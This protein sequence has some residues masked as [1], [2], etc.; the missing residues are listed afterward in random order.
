MELKEQNKDKYLS[1]KLVEVIN[2]TYTFP[3]G[4]LGLK[5]ISFTVEEGE[6]VVV[7]GPNGSGKTTLLL[8]LNGL[9]RGEGIIRLF[10]LDLNQKTL[11][12]IRK[13]LGLVFQNPDDQLFMPTVLDDVAFS[14]SYS[15]K[16]DLNKPKIRQ[17]KEDEGGKAQR[18]ISREAIVE[19]VRQI[20]KELNAENLMER[21]TFK[22]S[23][24]EKKKIALAGVLIHEPEILLLDEPT[25][26]LEPATRR[27]L[28]NYLREFKKTVIAT[29]QDMDF[30]WE[31]A[32]KVVLLNQGRVVACGS[33][34]EILEN[35]ALL[36]ANSLELPLVSLLRR[37][38]LYP[39]KS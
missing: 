31:L 24:G 2:L 28:I 33:K 8:N 4:T 10:G 15:L 19:K 37:R 26:G 25:L 14:L 5:N 22:L 1:R 27:W 29:T 17:K 32:D 21:S 6:K 35:K 34:E 39:Q 9:L 16:S 30:A 3:D 36:E 13:R 11:P 7:I 20:L 23:L 12:Q 18:P 38:E